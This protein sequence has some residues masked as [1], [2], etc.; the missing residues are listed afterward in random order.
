MEMKFL[1]ILLDKTW[2]VRIVVPSK[3]SKY[4]I[5]KASIHINGVSL[6]I[7]KKQKKQSFEVNIIPHTLFITS[8]KNLKK[9]YLVNV[10]FDIFG[11]YIY[12]INN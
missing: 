9:N 10:E 2:I 7:S 6:T 12:E 3:Y 8:L 5:E 11:K 1:V 4:L